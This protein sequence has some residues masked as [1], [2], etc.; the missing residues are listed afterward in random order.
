MPKKKRRKADSRR[1]AAV[2]LAAEEARREKH[3]ALVAER[4]GDPR[5]VQRVRTATGYQVTPAAQDQQE[6]AEVFRAQRERFGEKFGR[7]PGPNDL[8]IFDPDADEPRPLDPDKMTAELLATLSDD[9]PPEVRAVVEAFAEVG[10]FVTAENQHTFSAEEVE[11]W[12]RALTSRYEANGVPVEYDQG[13][14]GV[15]EDGVWGDVVFMAADALELAAGMVMTSR[16]LRVAEELQARLEE[17]SASEPDGEDAPAVAEVVFAV[18]LGWMI[19]RPARRGP[20][21]CLTHDRAVY[22]AGRRTP[23]RGCPAPPVARAR[24]P[25]TAVLPCSG[26][27]RL[28]TCSCDPRSAA[29]PQ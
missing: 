7:D 22:P 6:L 4:A 10:Y 13:D 24:R 11:V 2:R 12:E 14:D 9:T 26:A 8:L 19:G 3:A 21:D 28:P 29:G 15:D 17:A 27:W 23:C 25:A 1:Q 20:S 16:D 5:F 18:F